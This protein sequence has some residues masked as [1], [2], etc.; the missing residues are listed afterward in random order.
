MTVPVI[1]DAEKEQAASLL[2]VWLGTN[3]LA[4]AR[5]RKYID[6]NF[7]GCEQL[8]ISLKTGRIVEYDVIDDDKLPR[9]LVDIAG[10]ELFEGDVG[11]RL[12]DMVIDSV[13][14]KDPWQIRRLQDDRRD[15]VWDDEAAEHALHEVHKKRWI[16]GGSWARQFVNELGFPAQFSGVQSPPEPENF[17]VAERRP[18]LGRLED[19]QRNLKLQ[20]VDVIGGNGGKRCILRLPTGAGKTRIAVEAIVEYWKKRPS[21]VRWVVWI[22]DKEE[23]CEQ[24]VQCF[25][26]IWEEFG[27]YNEQLRIHR[28]WGRRN[29]PGPDDYG[30]IVAGISKLHK[31]EQVVPNG[32]PGLIGRMLNGLGLVVVD[33]AHHAIAPTYG[34]VLSSLGITKGSSMP[35]RVPLVGLTATP[36]RTADDETGRL[37]RR[38]GKN[39]LMPSSNYEP[40]GRFN[41]DWKN[42]HYV[43]EELTKRG[44]LSRPSFRPLE[45]KATFEMDKIESDHL[46]KMNEFNPSLLYRV[47]IDTQRNM[48]VFN[49]ISAEVQADKTVIFFG[50]NIN[51]ALMMSKI[52]N[53]RG[54][55]SAAVTG[56]TGRGARTEYINMFRDG[57][58]RVLCNYQV[59]TTGFDAPKTD[60]V[61]IA[62]PTSSRGMYEQMVGRGLRGSKFGGTDECTIIT[63]FDN[64]SNYEHER[65]RLG[66]E[67]YVK[68]SDIMTKYDREKMTAALGKVSL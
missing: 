23:L 21:G 32:E 15:A 61:I 52:L 27:E 53:D 42:W 48:D 30:I 31:Y 50:T 5:L 43:I 54:T 38:F 58:I 34:T 56:S 67:E 24:A 60:S 45:T 17:E 12:R 59:L 28:V 36:F 68:S 10:V 4:R 19:F 35:C 9:F 7:P 25:K 62:R 41:D 49:A 64:I 11:K 44:V 47:G 6:E 2:D 40:V 16:P 57:R 65:V 66:Y 39:L 33:E 22:A 37:L 14:A 13:Y 18:P 26:Q 46:A 29:L 55:P 1:G 63:V 8:Y 51:Q 3:R 20:L